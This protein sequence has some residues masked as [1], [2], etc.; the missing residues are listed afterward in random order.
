MADQNSR[1]LLRCVIVTPEKTVLDVRA[2][3]VSLPLDDGSRGVAVGHTP[4]IGRLG[5]GVVRMA[6]VEGRSAAETTVRTFVEG[7]FAEVSGDA[8]TVITRQAVDSATLDPAAARA[9]LDK[10]KAETA[11][12]DEA[13]ASRMAAEAVARARL[14]AAERR[15]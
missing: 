7:G 9:D 1:R 6:G 11:T 12:G 13:I 4:F 14:R 10:L 15:G 3:T 8:V 5:S 2:A